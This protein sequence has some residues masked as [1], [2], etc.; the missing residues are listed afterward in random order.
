MYA[1]TWMR[2][3]HEW[4]AEL[5]MPAT[6]LFFFFSSTESSSNVFEN[7]FIVF[8]F[9]LLHSAIYELR[10][11]TWLWASEYF[12]KLSAKMSIK[13]PIEILLLL[14]LYWHNNEVEMHDHC[15]LFIDR[16]SIEWKWL[17]GD[18]ECALKITLKCQRTVWDDCTTDRNSD[19]A[20]VID[21]NA[22]TYVAGQQAE[23]E[24]WTIVTID[25]DEHTIGRSDGWIDGRTKW[26]NK[27]DHQPTICEYMLLTKHSGYIVGCMYVWSTAPNS[28]KLYKWVQ[29]FFLQKNII[30]RII[31]II[32]TIIMYMHALSK[33]YQSAQ[34]QQQL[35]KKWM[36][37]N[38]FFLSFFLPFSF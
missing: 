1:H 31:T 29:Y 34:T 13:R 30:F 17:F 18:W 22:D 4:Y 7:S 32:T 19:N 15:L 10:I 23:N 12:N 27:L 11:P 3:M 16:V 26:K 33:S 38:F 2:C 9:F 28:A 20:A 5:L 14:L 24:H 6:F 37:N 35:H 21:A 25:M 8:F 36:L